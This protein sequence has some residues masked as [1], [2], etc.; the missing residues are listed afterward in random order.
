VLRRHGVL[1]ALQDPVQPA[2]HGERQD[3]LTVIRVLAEFRS[4]SAIDQMK[5]ERLSLSSAI[6]PVALQR[7]MSRS[8]RSTIRCATLMRRTTAH[9][10][11]AATSAAG[12]GSEL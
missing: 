4:R 9:R 5:T 1:G 8:L 7:R 6:A 10:R 12:Q 3:D 2:Q 11:L